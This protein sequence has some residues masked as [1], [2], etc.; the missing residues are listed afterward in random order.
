MIIT[1]FRR[2]VLGQGNSFCHELFAILVPG[3][4]ALEA[5]IIYK[6]RISFFVP[7]CASQ[8]ILGEPTNLNGCN[9]LSQIRMDVIDPDV[10]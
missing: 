8:T 9:N 10:Q 1:I 6:L 2:H 7:K 5:P 3:S 4:R